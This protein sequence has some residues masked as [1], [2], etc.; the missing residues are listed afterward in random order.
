MTRP[1]EV[2]TP[3]LIVG[4]GL[5]GLSTALFLARQGIRS[6]LI[7]RRPAVSLL[8][9]AR[10]FNPRTLEIFRS[11]GLERRIRERLSRL[12]ALPEMIGAK[13]LADPERFRID[14]LAHRRPPVTVTPTEWAMIDQDE[15]EH[16]VRTAG[17]E[18]GADVRFGTELVDF[19]AD[20]DDVVAV[21]REART[22]AQWRIRA[23]YLVAADGHRA[24]IRR[25]L[26]IG[27]DGPGTL[28]DVAYFVFDANL[29]PVLHGRRFLLAYLDRPASGTALVPLRVAGRW[30]LAVPYTSAN[31]DDAAEFTEQR[32]T[33]LVREAV[34][35]PDLEI[36]L[37]PPVPGWNRTVTTGTIGG[38]VAQRYRAGRVFFVGDAAHVVPP[39]GF[40]GANTGVADA[41]NLAWKLA[42]VL[43]GTARDA[44]LDTYEAE[45]RPVAELTLRQAMRLFDAYRDGTAGG[46][47][48]VDDVAMILGY[49]YPGAVAG[50]DDG[51]ADDLLE[52]P[53]TATGRPGSRAPHVWLLLRAGERVS[54]LDLFTRAYTLLVGPDGEGWSPAARQAA[55]E[56]NLRLDVYRIG[57]DLIDPEDQMPGSYGIGRAGASLVRPDG[58]VAWRAA[59]APAQPVQALRHVFERL[60][61]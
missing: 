25:R 1:Q 48:A 19:D 42:S 38:W 41:H 51:A 31:G 28:F 12:A 32:C 46:V 54:T 9:Q 4:G 45:R 57:I 61:G 23:D 26:G 20:T 3:V 27:D 10:A 53:C 37:V 52:D 33:E 36:S 29:G 43:G 15:L 35:I 16:I 50:T 18:S 11:M 6:T 55:A 17:E 8:P 14:L 59:R 40:Y 22:G 5:T 58:F 13:T 47:G 34:G 44:L 7:E 24:G 49:R 39:S 2:R 56:A 21:V 30:S 60:Q